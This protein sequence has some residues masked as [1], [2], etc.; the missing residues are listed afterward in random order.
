MTRRICSPTRDQ[1]EQ[2]MLTLSLTRQTK[3]TPQASATSWCVQGYQG[4]RSFG[5]D[6][7]PSMASA[8]AIVL[9]PEALP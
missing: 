4:R 7:T 2:A 3:Q 1:T 9:N 6:H 8:F 5:L